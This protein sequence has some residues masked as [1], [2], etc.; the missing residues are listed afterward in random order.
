MFL[1]LLVH[2]KLNICHFL[3]RM[4]ANFKT[5]WWFFT[6]LG[7]P[8]F[9]IIS[10]LPEHF[11]WGLMPYLSTVWILDIVWPLNQHFNLKNGRNWRTT[12]FRL[13]YLI[14]IICILLHRPKKLTLGFRSAAELSWGLLWGDTIESNYLRTS[15]HENIIR[16]ERRNMLF[17]LPV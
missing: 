15:M 2:R 7:K 8:K 10:F 5:V 1:H 14:G 3:L 17:T 6:S 13:R 16:T 9:D 11:T 12:F 4:S